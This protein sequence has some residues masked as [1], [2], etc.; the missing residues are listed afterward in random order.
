VHIGAMVMVVLF[1][2]ALSDRI[3]TMRKE[4]KVLNEHLEDKVR[5]RTEELRAAME[6]LEAMNEVL[7]QVN[8]D[9]EESNTRYKTDMKMAADVQTAFLPLEPPQSDDYDIALLFKPMSG[10]SG[11]FYDFYQTDGRID[12]VGIFDVSGH[13][14]SSG[15]LTLLAQSTIHR[16]FKSLHNDKLGDMMNKINTSLIEEIGHTSSYITG[17]LLR[18]RDSFVE[19]ANS[20]H[21]ELI[22]RSGKTKIAGKVI[23]PG[24]ESIVG[25]LLGID[26]LK[27]NFKSIK[28]Q[29]NR[30]DFLLAYTDSL[31]ESRNPQG[32]DH[33]ERR[34]IKSLQEAP[35]G[36][37]MEM[38]GY[39]ME[40][41]YSFTGKE[42]KL[43]D[44]ITVICIKKK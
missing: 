31:S 5:E 12:G 1:S 32:E 23:P 27:E 17:I 36:T 43:N 30:G 16:N 6:E 14:I 15:L 22:Y 40:Q 34:I 37:A 24:G 38:L 20:G 25:P 18:F 33:N 9:I 8:K 39:I 2:I 35:D 41:F 4:L 21:P 29:F 19:Y 3:N 28:L 13:G 26:M 44:D 11:D 10:V 42:N 7:T